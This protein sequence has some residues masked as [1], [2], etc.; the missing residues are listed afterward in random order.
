MPEHNNGLHA[1]VLGG[2]LAGMCAAAA[3]AGHMGKVTLIERDLYPDGPHWRRGVPQSRHTHNLLGAGQRALERL[4]P[5]VLADLGEQG[6][7]DVRMPKDM[8]AMIPGG[9]MERFT[10]RH[11]VLSAT[12]D[13]ID[14]RVRNHL[15]K[16]P[17][18][19]IRQECEAVGLLPQGD[20]IRGV[21]LRERETGA[22]TG[23]G[24]PYEFEADFVV[25]TTGRNSQSC[26]WLED[27][28][29]GTV[30]ESVVDAQCAYATCIFAIPPDHKA[31]WKCIV[32]QSTPEVPRQGIL[33]PIEGNRWM[34]SVSGVGGERPPLDH[35]GMVDFAKTLR[36]TE[37]YDQIRDAEPL[38][39]VYGSGRTENK[40]RHY[41]KLTRWPDRFVVMGDAA[42]SF[43]PAYG[44][45][46]SVAAT[47]AV[48]IDDA[49]E[50]AGTRDTGCIP[51]GLASGLRKPIAKRVDGAWMLSANSDLAY[52][53]AAPG[54]LPLPA[55]I[56]QRYMGR[57]VRVATR[58]GPAATALLDTY[59]LLAPPEA[60]FRPSVVAEVLRG[61]KSEENSLT[62]TVET[63]RLLNL[64][65]KRAKHYDI[66]S[67]R[68]YLIGQ[69]TMAYKHLAL[70]QLKLRPGDTVIDAGCGTGHN[71]PYLSKAVGP[72]G[73]VIG[74]DLT[75]SMLHLA[76]DR[77][78][79]HDLTNVTLHQADLT[80]FQFPQK[81]NGIVA[82]FSLTLIEGYATIVKNGYDA[83]VPG[84]R[85]VA[86]DYRLPDWWP[87]RAVPM[88]GPVIA[89]FGG[90]PD[91]L[92]NRH[93]WKAIEQGAAD[94]H[95]LTRYGGW[96]YVTTGIAP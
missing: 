35:Q 20:A 15:M 63:N 13:L 85:W 44:Q 45:G 75:D 89:P 62:G 29:Y 71:L 95:T 51:A 41:E 27:L 10:S 56:V 32:L 12:R 78:R 38:T 34:V 36:S 61:P 19:E 17:N 96:V 87:R 47:C 42:G 84:G 93:P 80:T 48:D 52:P 3:L 33:N 23:W 81:V 21:R 59:H 66:M 79:E 86:L 94:T 69:R 64:Y 54:P 74:I 1:V 28:G 24:E 37:I 60:V 83:L 55:R 67:N 91:M 88:L 30:E 70:D 4:F 49:F 68:L 90:R 16:L 22:K 73:K 7:V 76:E 46:I 2:S 18:I 50:A 25:D 72:S 82:C 58:R 92:L 53:G 5:G 57:L 8:L 6:V 77:I 14:W 26:N 40:R 31:D 43:N 65:R 39:E 11:V 9:W